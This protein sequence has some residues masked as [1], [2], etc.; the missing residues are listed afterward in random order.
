MVFLGIDIG[1]TSAKTILLDK[2]Q[3]IL[4]SEFSPTGFSSSQ[5]ADEIMEKVLQMGYQDHEIVSVATGYGRVSVPYAHKTLTEISCHAKG[6]GRIFEAKDACIIDIGGQDTKIIRTR[7]GKVMDF[8]M[9]DKCSAGTGQFLTIMADTLH[10]S[11]A[12][13]CQAAKEGGGVEISSMCTVFAQ[14]EVVSLI[15]QGRSKEDIAFAIIDSLAN[16]VKSLSSKMSDNADL[17]YLTGG[18]CEL[19]YI[20]KSIS[21]AIEKEVISLPMARY[22]GAMGAAMFAAELHANSKASELTP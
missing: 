8:L 15:G 5:K 6:V 11:L 7:N 20:I 10:L 2:N 4:H 14:S 18:L 22:A 3:N 21:K 9:N 12:E 17:V 16:K 1:S 13:M 19:D